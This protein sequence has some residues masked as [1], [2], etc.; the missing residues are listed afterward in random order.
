MP[1]A[2]VAT[3]TRHGGDCSAEPYESDSEFFVPSKR[4]QLPVS[5]GDD[6]LLQDT[7]F[8]ASTM[9]TSHAVG[10]QVDDEE[11]EHRFVAGK[12]F[13]NYHA[14]GSLREGLEPI[15][16]FS[17]RYLG[18]A[19]T[20][21]MAGACFTFLRYGYRPLLVAY[22]SMHH[23]SQYNAA[24]Y[25]LDWPGAFSV[26]IGL[27]SDCVPLFGYRRKSYI[28]LGWLV[29]LAAFIG[30]LIMDLFRGSAITV[31]DDETELANARRSMPTAEQEANP[32]LYGTLYVI[33]S[34]VGCCGLQIAWVAALAMM[35]EFAQ[36]EPLYQRGHLA[37]VVLL[38]YYA[39]ALVVQGILT[40]LLFPSD[41]G[42]LTSLMSLSEA[43]VFL[44]IG[45]TIPLPFAIYLLREDRTSL[46]TDERPPTLQ[47]LSKG[48]S[49]LWR[50]CQQKVVYL[51][52]SF[53]FAFVMIVGIYNQN[54]RD[55]LARWCSVSSANQLNVQVVQSGFT[56]V[57][58]LH[59]KHWMRNTNWKLVA[60]LGAV[61]FVV[62]FL[63]ETLPIVFNGLRAKWFYAITVGL[64]EWPKSWLK[65]FAVIPPTEIA[66]VGSEG[67]TMGIVLSFQVL[68]IASAHTLSEWLS[69]ATGTAVTMSDVDADVTH[70]RMSVLTTSLVYYG[71]N[72]AGL[73]TLLWLPSGKLDAQQLRAFGGYSRSWGAAIVALFV[74]LLA[75][76]LVVNVI[77]MVS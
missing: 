8:Y 35:I 53:L 18:L 55:A 64:I 28:I 41:D 70:T 45:S 7:Y 75:F 54:V 61:L 4:S 20:A 10:L 73:I 77:K 11:N 24:K 56:V 44:A 6:A 33:F 60:G 3:P 39:A 63:T 13:F 21:V 58:L 68:S 17:R 72:L 76:V 32:R 74:V 19:A 31:Y 47:A 42:G 69:R 9:G 2:A 62:I 36:R 25:L 67:V 30:I 5:L 14:F 26:F 46:P 37:T 29:S 43:G 52:L 38:L 57:G 23:P 59:A 50:F 65:L 71:V 34:F 16:L 22:L 15:K 12:Q 51:I 27:F 66:N 49:D 48:V 1:L 40:R